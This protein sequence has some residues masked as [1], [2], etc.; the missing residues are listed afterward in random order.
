MELAVRGLYRWDGEEL[1]ETWGKDQLVV[2]IK[3][4]LG[5]KEKK[6]NPNIEKLISKVLE[7]INQNK[8]KEELK[9]LFGF[10]LFTKNSLKRRFI[11]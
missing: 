10:L 9:K 8:N 5:D 3:S 2:D 1:L 11:Q 6:I 4:Q 7:E